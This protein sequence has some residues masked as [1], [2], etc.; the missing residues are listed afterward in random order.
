MPPLS[1][2]GLSGRRY[3]GAWAMFLC[4]VACTSYGPH[5]DRPSA[6][7]AQRDGPPVH[8]PIDVLAVPDATP[9]PEPL[10]RYGNPPEYTVQHVNYRVMKDARGYS[11][12]G[13][14]SWY[15]AKFHGQRTSSGE[16]YDMYAMSAAHRTL[17]IPS[18]ARVTNLHNGESVVVRINDRGPFHGDRLIDLSY[19]AAAR[20]GILDR[21]TGDVEVR[22]IETQKTVTLQQPAFLQVAAFS[23]ASS[24]Q[25]LAQR[26]QAAAL[27]EP[28]VTSSR[29]RNKTVYRVRLGPVTT[30]DRLQQVRHQLSSMG[31]DAPYVV[32]D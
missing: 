10:S 12:S 3:I 19:T 21:G 13:K 6:T 26:L 29:A 11:R 30:P 31:F 18:Y 32:Y 27:P 20:L 1:S 17:P 23:A 5:S 2:L 7:Q 15:G 9:R 28:Q 16:P 25:R 4:L 8:V 22:A 14:A 24:A